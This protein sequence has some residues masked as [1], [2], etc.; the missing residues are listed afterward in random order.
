MI[1]VD[2]SKV[3]VPEILRSDRAASYF[4]FP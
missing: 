3:P 2:R 1:Y 4:V